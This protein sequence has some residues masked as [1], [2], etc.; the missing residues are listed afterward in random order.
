[1]QLGKV[2]ETIVNKTTFYLKDNDG[3]MI[4][5][6]GEILTFTLLITKIWITNEL[7]NF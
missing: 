7:Q 4:E 6:N 2:N 3:R 1:M 5:F